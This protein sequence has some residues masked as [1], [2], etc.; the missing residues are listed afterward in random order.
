MYI[1]IYIYIY[2]NYIMGINFK[3]YFCCKILKKKKYI[4]FFSPKPVLGTCR[5]GQNK[6][7]EFLQ[8][9]LRDM[10]VL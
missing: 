9:I 1:Y 6:K 7:E 10:S 5:L 3:H 8:V 4:F 2:I